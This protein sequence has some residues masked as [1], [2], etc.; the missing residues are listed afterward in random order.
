MNEKTWFFMKNE[1]Y[2]GSSIDLKVPDA[3]LV[4]EPTSPENIYLIC[5][6]VEYMKALLSPSKHPVL[7]LALSFC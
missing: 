2:T 4:E 5:V 3:G 7:I 1:T 6:E